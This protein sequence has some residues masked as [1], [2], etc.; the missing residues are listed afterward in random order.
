MEFTLFTISAFAM[1]FLA[2]IP[3]GPVQVEV[4]R[5]SING[6]LTSSIAV[7]AGAFIADALYGVIAL[8]GLAPFLNNEIVRA[9]FWLGGA[10]FL[11]FL[12]V[13]I[14]SDGKKQGDIGSKKSRL[15][16]EKWGLLSGFIL[17]GINPMMILWWLMGKRLFLD[18]GLVK[19]FSAAIT[20]WFIVLGALGL[21]VYLLLLAFFLNWTKHYISAAKMI[22]I[23]R[24]FG[25][26]LLCIAGYFFYSSIRVI[27]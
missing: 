11:V 19:T 12:A 20:L 5:R 18:L 26:V 25:V 16:K 22:W 27:F 7:I 6:Y 14:F 8:F 17:A 4:A 21:A 15:K 3:S 10:V 13:L 9:F 23:N 24:A 2:A 1:G